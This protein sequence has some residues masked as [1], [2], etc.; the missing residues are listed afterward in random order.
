MKNKLIAPFAVGFLIAP[1]LA[2][3]LLPNK[4]LYKWHLV[5]EVDPS[6]SNRAALTT[7]TVAVLN[8]RLDG[9][10][11]TLFKVDIVGSPENGRVRVDLPAFENPD[12][13]KNLIASRGLLQVVHIV[14]DPSPA[15]C[16]T[17]ATEEEAMGA[18]KSQGNRR[19]L[20]YVDSY[21]DQDQSVRWVV[22]AI[23]A[24]VEGRDLRSA[25]AIPPAVGD[26]YEIL[27]TLRTDAADKFAAWTAANI[28][29]YLGVV[30]NDEL[31][32]LAYI[33][34]PIADTGM[35]EGRFTKQVAEDLAM[36]LNSGP[37]PA[38]I[39]IIEEGKN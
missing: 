31:K 3:S 12:R 9:L 16:Q 26:D 22:S 23:P 14:S 10:G 33:K 15:P 5:L 19:V 34:S 29:Q 24:I 7:E 25:R 4:S 21:A 17:Y 37:L 1:L 2:C 8:G 39:K 18:I 20:R 32:S 36:V 6:V 27:F 28:N 38:A 35:I 11:V 30:L 13:I